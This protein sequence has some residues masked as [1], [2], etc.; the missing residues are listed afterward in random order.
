MH[1]NPHPLETLCDVQQLTLEALLDQME[2]AELEKLMSLDGDR[3]ITAIAQRAIEWYLIATAA[4]CSPMH[5]AAAEKK[6]TDAISLHLGDR[7]PKPA[8]RG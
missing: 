4:R 1:P 2:I 5:V 7:D 6:L 8:K 3:R